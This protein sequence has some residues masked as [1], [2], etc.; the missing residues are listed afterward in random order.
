MGAYGNSRNQAGLPR[1]WVNSLPKAKNDGGG[2]G[3]EPSARCAAIISLFFA[4]TPTGSHLGTVSGA[5]LCLASAD[6][7]DIVL[8]G[9]TYC[10]FTQLLNKKLRV[11]L[12][13]E[14]PYKSSEQSSPC[15]LF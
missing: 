12:S 9:Y 11:K 14:L 13:T 3:F 10:Y 6:T 4:S 7:V 1:R 15:A 2:R 5:W 8:N